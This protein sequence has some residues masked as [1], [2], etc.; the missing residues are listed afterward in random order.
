MFH[1]L[2]NHCKKGEGQWLPLFEPNVI[3]HW[4]DKISAEIVNSVL[5]IHPSPE[6]AASDGLLEAKTQQYSILTLPELRDPSRLLNLLNSLPFFISVSTPDWSHLFC[7]TAS[8]V[9]GGGTERGARDLSPVPFHS[10][11]YSLCLD[12]PIFKNY[13][14][15]SNRAQ[16]QGT[17]FGF[18]L[19]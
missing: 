9:L 6:K 16:N 2:L 12:Y 15:L 14:V 17:L 8:K 11:C 3:R 5:S 19:S 4:T 1:L 13:N 7:F 10:S 18:W